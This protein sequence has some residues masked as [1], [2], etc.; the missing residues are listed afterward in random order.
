MYFNG[1]LTGCRDDSYFCDH[2]CRKKFHPLN[3]R[4]ISDAVEINIFNYECF[5]LSVLEDRRI[6][7]DIRKLNNR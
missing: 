5:S 4:S 2:M 3:I 6:C 1:G 7:I